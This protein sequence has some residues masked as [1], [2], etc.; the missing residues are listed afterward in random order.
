MNFLAC[1]YN[2]IC[3]VR[4]GTWPVCTCK[5]AFPFG[6]LKKPSLL[7]PRAILVHIHTDKRSIPTT[8]YSASKRCVL[9]V[10]VS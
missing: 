4:D 2:Y 8:Q 10:V 1:L 5:E 9:L 6:L 7:G 3:T